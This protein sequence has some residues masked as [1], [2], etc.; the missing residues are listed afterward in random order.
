M[1]VEHVGALDVIVVDE[2]Q[3]GTCF[4]RRQVIVHQPVAATKQATG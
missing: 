1:V 2:V 4:A 3:V